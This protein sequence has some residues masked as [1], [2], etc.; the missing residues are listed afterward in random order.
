VR[1]ALRRSHSRM[2][3]RHRDAA[4]TPARGRRDPSTRHGGANYRGDETTPRDVDP[5]HSAKQDSRP[6][7]SPTSSATGEIRDACGRRAALFR[8]AQAAIRLAR[9][10]ESRFASP[11]RARRAAPDRPPWCARSKRSRA[12]TRAGQGSPGRDVLDPRTEA[13]PQ[14]EGRRPVHDPRPTIT[15]VYYLESAT[16]VFLARVTTIWSAIIREMLLDGCRDRM[17]SAT[18]RVDGRFRIRQEPPRDPQWHEARLVSGVD[19]T[20][21]AI[22]IAQED[23]RAEKPRRRRG[24][25][26]KSLEILKRTAAAPSC[27]TSYATCA[28]S[29]ELASAEID[30]SD[31]WSRGRPP[32]M[33]MR[34]GIQGHAQRGLSPPRA[35][36]RRRPSSARSPELRDPSTRCPRLARGFRSP[37]RIE[38]INA[39]GQR[40]RGEKYQIPARHPRPPAR[41]WEG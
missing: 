16:R 31:V 30:I 21:Q 3:L 7:T 13:P 29:T 5:R 1:R 37:P 14:A 25:D 6:A 38:A 20:R 2:P 15:D 12:T 40:L 39:D 34:L 18:L 35:Y 10:G 11:R 24:R 36:G 17:T 33:A 28:R 32:A 26:G 41:S 19:Y 22:S 9:R 8:D 23:A 4:P 27:F